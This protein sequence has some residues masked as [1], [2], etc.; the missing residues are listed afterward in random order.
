MKSFGLDGSMISAI[1]IA[2]SFATITVPAQSLSPADVVS[3]VRRIAPIPD[4]IARLRAF[5]AL[6]AKLSA[7]VPGP[8]TGDSGAWRLTE[9]RSKID[10]SPTV[11]LTLRAEN[12]V[13]GW[14]DKRTKPSLIVRYREGGLDSYIALGMTPNVERAD[15]ATVT[16]RFDDNNALDVRCSLSTDREAVFLPNAK[17]FIRQIAQSERMVL[18]FVP[19]NSNP[20]VTEFDTR[21]FRTALRPLEDASGWRLDDALVELEERLQ[22]ARS[23]FDRFYRSSIDRNTVS[24]VVEGNTWKPWARDDGAT[25]RIVEALRLVAYAAKPWPTARF[26]ITVYGT[27]YRDGASADGGAPFTSQQLGA[28]ARS[29][30]NDV[31]WKVE[32]YEVLVGKEREP[33]RYGDDAPRIL[34]GKVKSTGESVMIEVLSVGE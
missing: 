13:N 3:E 29:A 9:D 4:D 34:R 7:I 2:I 26:R 16:I 32:R 6:A 24:T 10:D 15:G 19:F 21:G 22:S 30:I 33:E 23:S 8:D 1:A 20:V 12:E 25:E 17:N 18:R 5:D 28:L 11:V 31:G 27:T 14:L